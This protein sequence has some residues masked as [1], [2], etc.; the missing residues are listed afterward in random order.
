[1]FIFDFKY[2]R[3]KAESLMHKLKEM[4]YLIRVLF[5]IDLS[6]TIRNAIKQH[7]ERWDGKG[8][9][10]GITGE[11]TSL[12]GRILQIADTF[13]ALTIKRLYKPL[14]S[15]ED[16]IEEMKKNSGTQFDPNLIII[17]DNIIKQNDVVTNI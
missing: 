17:F 11:E 6:D 16:A 8:Y 10:Y 13:S 12:E 2:D 7:Q 3:G 15:L 1:M 4:K 14:I 9:P 5:S